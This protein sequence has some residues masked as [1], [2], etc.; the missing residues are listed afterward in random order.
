MHPDKTIDQAAWDARSKQHAEF[1]ALLRKLPGW[2]SDVQEINVYGP[3]GRMNVVATSRTRQ[4]ATV[5]FR[6]LSEI[7]SKTKIFGAIRTCDVHIYA[8]HDDG[9]RI[10]PKMVKAYR[11]W[12]SPHN[13][14]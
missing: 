7:K 11:V 9:Q 4:A 3:P 5:M 8:R 13:Q 1:T 2:A 14:G 12:A 6:A 10:H